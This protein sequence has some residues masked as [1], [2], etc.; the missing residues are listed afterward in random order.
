MPA[1]HSEHFEAIVIGGGQG[2]ALA[3][4]L[5]QAGWKTALIEAQQVGGTCVNYGCTP[6][7]TLVASARTAYVARRAAEFGVAAGTVRTDW[8]KIQ[9]RTR[10]VVRE[11]RTEIEERLTATPQLEW[12]HGT[13]SFASPDSIIVKPAKR[14]ESPRLIS[15][16][17]IVIATGTRTALPP[18]EGIDDVPWLDAE[19]ILELRDLP[20]HLLIVGAGYIALEYAQMLR[21]LG[22]RVTIIEQDKELLPREDRDISELMLKMLSDDGIE[23]L[24]GSDLKHVRKQ[25]NGI[26]VEIDISGAIRKLRGSHLMFATGRKPNTESLALENCG[27][28]TTGQGHIKVN[29]ALRTNVSGIWAMGDVAGSPPFTHIAF[30]DARQLRDH[31]LDDARINTQ[32]RLYSYVIFTDPQLGRV[33]LTETEALEQGYPVRVAKL[34]VCD[35]A[36][37]IE[38]GETRGMLKAVVDS[39]T[40]RILGGSFLAYEGGELIAALQMAILGKLPYTALRDAPIAHPTLAESLNRLFLN[41]EA[42]S[43]EAAPQAGKNS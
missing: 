29:N 20:R 27:V 17:R 38:S 5:A 3:R 25:K 16:P 39:E 11:F 8:Q 2:A 22:V 28:R 7:K 18:L 33:G 13:A 41:L 32:N 4:Y 35:T 31:F 36:R 6:T 30:D 43:I 15:A 1:Q 40:N 23:M 12:I 37:G 21:R 19:T 9:K 24:F 26:E 42:A 14:G 34:P 10:R